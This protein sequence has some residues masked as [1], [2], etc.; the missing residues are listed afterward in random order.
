MPYTLGI[1]I[2]IASFGYAGVDHS[3]QQIAFS[4]V[5]IFEAAEN[6][7]DGASLAEPR[8]EKRGLR[9]VIHRRGLRK[10]A[11]RQLLA[12]HGLNTAAIDQVCSKT[13]KSNPPHSP[14]DWRKEGL[15]RRLT[16][17]EFARVLFHIA[18][19]RGFQ[20]NRK[21]AVANDLEGKKALSG[22][23]EL[24]VAMERAN[25]RTVGAYLA[26]LPK[27]RNGDG[28]YERFVTRDLLRSEVRQ[29]FAAQQ[30]FGNAK[31]T[32]ALLAEYAGNGD[33]A[34]RNTKEGD[35]I[36]FYQNPLQSS[37]HMVGYC[38]LEL[39][40]K[41][42]PKF[43]Y[44]AEL[45]V[46]WSKLN[47][48]KIRDMGGSERFLTA[49]ERNQLAEL[50]HK[51]KGGVSYKQARNAIGLS[52]E[53]RFNISYRKIKD[54]DNSWIAIRDTSEKTTF[55][56]MQGY[57]TLKEALDNGSATDWQRWIGVDRNKLDE[58]ARILSFY[59]DEK[60]IHI[61]LSALGL[62][63]EQIGKL[64]AINNFSKT[65]DLSCKA[66]QAILPYLQAG[67]TY[68]KACKEAGYHH[69]QKPR[70]ELNKIPPFEDIRNPVVNRA[71]AQARKV[72]NAIIRTYGM[73]E[74]II[75]ELSRDIGRNFKDR[76]DIEREQKKNQAYREEAKKH[77]A[78]IL[79]L[80]EDNITGEEI[81]KYRLW[82]EQEGFCPYSG[83]YIEPDTLRDP[84]ATQ[85]DHIIPYSRSWNDS[86][87]NKVLCLT[88]ENQSKGNRT[89]R[90]YLDENRLRALKVFAA[91]LP[92]KK[93]ENLLIERF[94]EEKAA[95]WKDRALNDT[96]YMARLLKNQ[97]ENLLSVKVHT[98]NGALTAH[99]RGAWG[100]PDK[101]R[102]NDRHHALD[103]IVLAC[104]SQSMVQQLANWNKYE[105]RS[106]NTAEKPRPPKPWESFREDAKA[107]IERI[108]VS[109]MP[110]RK[111]T[112]QA[113]QDTIRSIRST[114][115][116]DRQIIQRVKLKSLTYALLENMVDKERNIRLYTVLK[117]RL[118]QFDGKADKAFATPVHMPV[119]DPNKNGPEIHSIRVITNEKSGV[120]INGGLASNGDMVRVD[121]FQ[122]NGKYF[123]VPI[124]VHHFAAK[125]LPN[126]AIMQGKHEEEWEVM[127]DKDFIFS[128]YKNDL[129][130]IKSKKE[131]YLGYYLG[132]DRS[133][134]A[135]SVRTHDNDP[136]FGKDGIT[137]IGVKTLLA[138]EKYTVDYFGN[139]S[140][141]GS[142]G[143]REQRL[144]L[145]HS[146]DSESSEAEP[147]ERSAATR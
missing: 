120:E 70:K 39:N 54:E 77:I 19:R 53:E 131:D 110:V 114:E 20:T 25:A 116:G 4:G 28:S 2:G 92:P 145:A 93:A 37:E 95:A 52:D 38:T 43:S 14:W 135:I 123:L 88:G 69:S 5:H 65:V 141:E 21:S 82:K 62:H 136:G 90:E 144:G 80:P 31:A 81:L 79:R 140:P 60:Q 87:M 74:Q 118:D 105:A 6:P 64:S 72:M 84:M 139:I 86:Y 68:D 125:E 56:K 44:S 16:D 13:G 45:F 11:I 40:E 102:R 143:I 50:A 91:K 121:V 24:Q 103:A 106:R 83:E 78:E 66:I 35:G 36:A 98:R 129:V 111:V 142:P 85:I 9:R 15:E 55:L 109:R 1:D 46:L 33:V 18:K 30:K 10:R 3:V 137:R 47:H 32:D 126:K 132:T 108:F 124:Y 134:G 27:K 122:K 133:T 59:E 76:K 73:P 117:E 17:D 67:L 51:N 57:Q 26:V 58:I 63:P 138:F 130:R 12:E 71:M 41:R 48:T 113:H 101:D 146:D 22:A 96:R 29:L 61:M 42:A 128:L 104:S 97:L 99:L 147:I 23:R 49:D 112:G 94:D 127:D 8:R 34:K 75:V 115:D 100:F 89:P 7:K 107:S 119:N